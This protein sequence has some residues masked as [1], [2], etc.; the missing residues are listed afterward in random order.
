MDDDEP[1]SETRAPVVVQSRFESEQSCNWIKVRGRRRQPLISTTGER[2][3]WLAFTRASP[4]T[5]AAYS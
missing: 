4:A 1:A 3:Y 5:Q 2:N